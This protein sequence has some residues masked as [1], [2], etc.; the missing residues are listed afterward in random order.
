MK[1]TNE[2]KQFNDWSAEWKDERK[3][4]DANQIL[5]LWQKPMPRDWEREIWEG[6]LGYRKR[7]DDKGEQCTEKELFNGGSNG[8][9]LLFSGQQTYANYR[10]K[11]I[12]HNMPLANRRKGQVI[13]DAFGVLETGKSVRPLFI[14]VKVTANDPWFALLEN[15]QQIRLARACAQQIQAFVHENTEYQV[16]RGVWGLI[17]APESYYE[18][19]SGNLAK[20]KLL[21]DALKENTRARVAF[22]I[23]DS[24]AGGQIEIITQNWLVKADACE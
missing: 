1:T 12:Y 11:P 9:E 3:K 19:H 7:S 20:C 8:F 24:L 23:S 22:G 16:E 13:A 5:K 21:L 17:L 6:K 2:I 10:V 18:N 14:E 15:L 4:I